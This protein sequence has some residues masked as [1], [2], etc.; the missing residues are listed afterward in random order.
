[1]T[2]SKDRT[3]RASKGLFGIPY[4][5]ARMM[6]QKQ[7]QKQKHGEKKEGG[8]EVRE[9]GTERERDRER[10]GK[11]E[12]GKEIQKQTDIEIVRE[13]DEAADW[14]GFAGCFLFCGLPKVRTSCE[15]GNRLTE[16]NLIESKKSFPRFNEASAPKDKLEPMLTL[17]QSTTTRS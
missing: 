1:M 3:R 4:E 6:R 12:K 9:K 7:E 14:E 13:A 17:H 15:A 5:F 8:R 11:R 2:I 16:Q 10:K